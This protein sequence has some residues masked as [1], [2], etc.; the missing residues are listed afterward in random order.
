MQTVIQVLDKQGVL[1]TLK[2]WCCLCEL[3]KVN[4]S[5]LTEGPSASLTTSPTSCRHSCEPVCL[6]WWMA[7]KV[8]VMSQVRSW[9]VRTT[10]KTCVSGAKRALIAILQIWSKGLAMLIKPELQVPLKVTA[11][12]MCL[13][14]S[15]C[16]PAHIVSACSSVLAGKLLLALVHEFLA[17]TNMPYAQKVRQMPSSLPSC[18]FLLRQ[19]IVMPYQMSS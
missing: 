13:L 12:T 8:L 18:P 15:I 5:H 11:A 2:V 16:N 1:A 10:P 14:L 6:L 19:D 9:V 17:W 7:A 4:A 3:C